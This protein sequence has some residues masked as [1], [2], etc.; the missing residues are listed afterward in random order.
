MSRDSEDAIALGARDPHA[1]PR[2]RVKAP[3]LDL[4]L[5]R[6]REH[7]R[8]REEEGALQWIAFRS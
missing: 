6:G 2:Q 1:L 4:D 3:G 8:E 7:G 5:V